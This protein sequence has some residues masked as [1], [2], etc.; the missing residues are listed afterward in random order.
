MIRFGIAC[1][2]YKGRIFLERMLEATPSAKLGTLFCY[3]ASGQEA[4]ESDAIVATAQR[5]KI[6][7]VEKRRLERC[8]L[9]GFDVVFF[10]GWQYLLVNPPESAV[11]FHD[12]LL[13]R[14]RGFAPTVTAL[15]NGDTEIGVS[16]LAPAEEV[17]SG[18]LLGQTRVALTYPIKIA[19]ALRKQAEATA[20]LALRLLTEWPDIPREPQDHDCAT[21]SIWRSGED[22]QI[23]WGASAESICRFIDAVGWPYP[24]A[25]TRLNG[26]TI[27]VTDATPLPDLRFEI[28]QPGK[29]WRFDENKPVVVCGEG[30][31]RIDAARNAAGAPIRVKQLRTRLG[32]GG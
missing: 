11:V 26:E 14:Y 15:L 30:L 1:T 28:R 16:A 7:L 8:D 32:A 6:P 25:Y 12:A 27:T 22:G 23:D 4:S 19:D 2:G 5:L 21:Y 13:P 18:D 20:S 9:A 24:G 10:V 29:V 3:R 31:L 17:D